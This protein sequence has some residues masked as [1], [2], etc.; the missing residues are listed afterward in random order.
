MK[1]HIDVFIFT[2]VLW[3]NKHVKAKSHVL[4][5]VCTSPHASYLIL[6]PHRHISSMR[7]QTIPQSTP[8]NPDKPPVK[9]SPQKKKGKKH[10]KSVVL[11]HLD[12]PCSHLSYW[13]ALVIS[14]WGRNSTN[15]TSPLLTCDG[16]QWLTPSCW[17][18]CCSVR[19][20][21]CV[22]QSC[23]CCWLEKVW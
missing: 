7:G 10:I 5:S 1:M 18:G 19:P 22:K 16:A 12:S 4:R 23:T 15:I 14:R 6:W 3:Q 11:N 9:R 21:A 13:Q 2:S 17:A 8:A 20:V